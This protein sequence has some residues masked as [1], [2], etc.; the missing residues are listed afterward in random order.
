MSPKKNVTVTMRLLPA[1]EVITP[2]PSPTRHPPRHTQQVHPGTRCSLWAE[3]R[4]AD[5]RPTALSVSQSYASPKDGVA[6]AH[7]PGPHAPLH[8]APARARDQYHITLAT[9][10]TPPWYDSEP[11]VK[12][13]APALPSGASPRAPPRPITEQTVG[14]VRWFGCGVCHCC[15]LAR[16]CAQARARGHAVF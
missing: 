10:A 16:Y 9:Q 11:H 4:S 12:T 15:A 7:P 14:D 5:A 6:G 1:V 3:G 2:P 13:R 8:A